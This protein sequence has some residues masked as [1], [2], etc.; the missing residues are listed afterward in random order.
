[1]ESIHVSELRAIADRAKTLAV[2]AIDEIISAIDTKILVG[3]IHRPAE[4]KPRKKRIRKTKASEFPPPEKLTAQAQEKDLP[5][6]DVSHP[7]YGKPRKRK[8]ENTE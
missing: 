4:K 6:K 2:D 8:E 1:M 5:D 3:D 7:F